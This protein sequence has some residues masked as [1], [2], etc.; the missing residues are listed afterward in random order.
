[1]N[2]LFFPNLSRKYCC[3]ANIVAI[4][5]V[6]FVSVPELKFGDLFHL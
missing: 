5:C 3:D 4:K 2:Y 1:M 6:Q